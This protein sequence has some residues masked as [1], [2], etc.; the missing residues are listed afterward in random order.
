MSAPSSE[1]SPRLPDWL[2]HQFV[3]ELPLHLILKNTAGQVIYVN[4]ETRIL[5]GL[6]MDQIVGKTDHDLFPLELAKKYR[7]DDE[8]VMATGLTIE[9]IESH[10]VSAHARWERRPAAPLPSRLPQ[11]ARAYAACECV[12]YSAA[13]GYPPCSVRSAASA[14][15]WIYP[16][17]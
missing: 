15:V 12:A 3:D 13:K 14:V 17:Q 11:A 7:S 10:A 16:L 8:H 9:H 2:V 5:I 1:D 4:R 6:P